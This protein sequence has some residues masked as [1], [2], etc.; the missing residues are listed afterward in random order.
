MPGMTPNDMNIRQMTRE[1]LHTLVEW[2]ALEGWNP[3][4]NDTEVFWATDPEGFVAA[5]IDGELIGG[6]SIVAYEKRYGFIGL[7]IVRPEYRGRGL[8]DYLWEQLK[9]RL[10]AR[11]DANA[12]IGLDGVFNMQDYYGRGG[13]RFVCRDLRFEGWGMN[14]PQAKH[15]IDASAVPFERIDA[16]DRRHFP[17]SRTTF[18][19]NWIHPPG[20]HALAAVDGDEIRGYAVMRPCRSG[21]KIGPL[22][23]AN[24][25]VAESLFTSIT[26][27]VP[28]EPIFL[29]VPEINSEA[30]AL[31]ARYRMSEVFGCAR[32][33]LGAIP[34]LPDA[35][36]FGVTTFELG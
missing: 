12:A 28:G 3:G 7:F 8:G 19:R 29:D 18:L 6:G 13:F 5:E 4:L 33:L 26:S 23:A 1:E 31:A 32:M 30:L 10:S 22:F 21:Y 20:G 35:E 2:A 15:V 24:P 11:L 34:Q 27:R 25:T 36:I 14:Y 16:Y 9:R 17:A